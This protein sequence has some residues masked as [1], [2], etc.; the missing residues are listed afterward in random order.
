MCPTNRVP[1][2]LPSPNPSL[3]GGG[4]RVVFSG[5]VRVRGVMAGTVAREHQV[6][7]RANHRMFERASYHARLAVDEFLIRYE[8]ED[9]FP[10]R[11]RVAGCAEGQHLIS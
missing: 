6:L 4:G 9:A 11:T 1:N 10:S 8:V 2:P 3:M 5:D 7:G